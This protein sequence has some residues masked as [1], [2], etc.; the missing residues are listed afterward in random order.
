MIRDHQLLASENERSKNRNR[1]GKT[2][3]HSI[4]LGSSTLTRDFKNGILKTPTRHLAI[5][6]IWLKIKLNLLNT[7]S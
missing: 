6:V 4:I 1:L 2:A 5:G 3:S 7:R